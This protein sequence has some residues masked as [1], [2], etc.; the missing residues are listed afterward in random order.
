MYNDIQREKIHLCRRGVVPLRD[1]AEDVA[2][3]M[4]ILD[5]RDYVATSQ[6]IYLVWREYSDGFGLSWIHMEHMSD[7]EIAA[8][9]LQRM[10][11][12]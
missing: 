7:D 6:D 12:F 11:P 5:H 10:K 8:I 2:R 3:V 9:I 1:H 4:R